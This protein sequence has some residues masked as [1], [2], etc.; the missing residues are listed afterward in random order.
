MI[1]EMSA[2]QRVAVEGVPVEM[3]PTTARAHITGFAALNIP[4]AWRLG[5]YWHDA[6]FDVKPTCP[7]KGA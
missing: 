5:G 7:S 3:I 2:N 4:H 1:R 6:W